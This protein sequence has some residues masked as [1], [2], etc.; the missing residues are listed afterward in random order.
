MPED[1]LNDFHRE[2]SERLKAQLARQPHAS[3]EEALAQYD[4]IKRQSAR[5]SESLSEPFGIKVD[6]PEGRNRAQRIAEI[7]RKV[8]SGEIPRRMGE[9]ASETV[10]GDLTAD[11][12][13]LSRRWLPTRLKT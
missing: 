7:A 2:H 11:G 1:Y 6:S 13:K 4:R 10:R 12:L 9:T 3:L 5:N 8:E